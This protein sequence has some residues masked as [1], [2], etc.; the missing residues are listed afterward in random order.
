PVDPLQ[1]LTESF[2]YDPVGNRASSHLATG[3]IHDAA[4]R[5]L[6]DSTFTLSYDANGNLVEQIT[7]ATGDRTVHTYNVENQLIQV[8]KFTVAGGLSPVL[9]ALYRYDALGRRIAKEVTQ[10]GA[11]TITRY[12]YDNEDILLEFDGANVLQARYTHGRGIDEPL[13]MLRGTQ[14]FFYHADGLG[15]VWDLTDAAGTSVRSY[16][17]DSFG[18]LLSTT[19]TLPN[20]YTYTARELDSETGLFFYRA[21]YYHPQLGRFLQEDPVAF[22]GGINF[23]TY[24]RNNPVIFVDP[25]GLDIY[26]LGL[27]SSAFVGESLDKPGRGIGKQVTLGIAFDTETW[28]FRTFQSV[29]VACPSDPSVNVTGFNIGLGPV[30]GVV[31]GGFQDFFGESREETLVIGP[32]GRTEITTATG[33]KGVAVAGGGRGIGLSGTTITTETKPLEPELFR[34][35]VIQRALGEPQR[36]R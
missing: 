5:L 1:Q 24:A 10:A 7:K 35:V 33:K 21:R 8:E 25:D 2:T 13:I 31:K 18:N 23:Y 26:F 27:G 9:T 17:Y 34:R 19:G 16:T 3:Q 14:S 6:E 32:F 22:L 28:T 29:G 12:I 4:N 36:K 11:T 20:P 30:G 15:S